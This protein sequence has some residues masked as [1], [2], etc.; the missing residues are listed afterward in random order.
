MKKIYILLALNLALVTGSKAQWVQNC[1]QLMHNSADPAMA[2]LKI[3]I[4]DTVWVT[5]FAF[6]QSTPRLTF[7]AGTHTMGVSLTTATNQAQSI[8]QQTF[9]IGGNI[10]NQFLTINGIQNNAQTPL[11]VLQYTRGAF[12]QP[13]PYSG[14]ITFHHGATTY[15]NLTVALTPSM[16]SGTTYSSST[17]LY[18]QI[19]GYYIDMPTMGGNNTYTITVSS[20]NSLVSSFLLPFASY[21]QKVVNVVMNSS[22]NLG[23]KGTGV[24]FGLAIVPANGGSVTPITKIESPT[25]INKIALNTLQVQV[26]PNPVNDVLNVSLSTVS[27]GPVTLQ[28]TDITGKRIMSESDLPAVKN[29]LNLGHLSPGIYFLTILQG[30][31]TKTVKVVKE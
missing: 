18:G 24:G 21:A 19:A 29:T 6:Q 8:I 16:V 7:P 23:Q 22:Y 3:W 13:S 5:N 14:D 31:A 28:I 9:E 26:S 25:T 17:I 1:V 12:G 2:N 30:Q 4:N 15:P 27:T 10:D 20:G 11:T